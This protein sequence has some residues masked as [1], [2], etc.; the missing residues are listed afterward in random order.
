MKKS[1]PGEYAL[2]LMDIQMPVMDG[3]EAAE[4]IRGLGNPE[5][6]HIPI[7]ALSADAFENDRR[8]SLECGMD[9]HLTK[10]MD[11]DEVVG[12]MAKALQ[13]HKTLYGDR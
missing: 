6:A 4:A 12:A 3:R 10:P 13:R 1:E 8:L 7:I 5:L 9:E 11:I 2:V